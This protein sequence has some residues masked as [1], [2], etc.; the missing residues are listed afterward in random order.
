VSGRARGV[1]LAAT[2]AR[3]P[4]PERGER[5]WDQF[6]GSHAKTLWACDFLT[7]RMLTAKG[8]KFAF[9]LVFVHP[10]TRRAHVSLST[11]SSDAAWCAAVARR[12]RRIGTARH[13]QSQAPAP[14]PRRQVRHGDR[15]LWCGAG[16]SRDQFRPTAAPV[17]Q[18]EIR[19]RQRHG[20]LI[21]H[22]YRKA[23]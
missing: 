18:R 15:N 5:T 2:A 20:G 11:T 7:L 16:Q 9:A 17:E 22:Y 8:L 3:R 1:L 14:R 23:A 19:C 12:F 10:K 13:S 21:K 4:A 6:L